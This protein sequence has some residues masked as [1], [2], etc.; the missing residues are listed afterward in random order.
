VQVF[1]R[2][3]TAIMVM[4]DNVGIWNLRAENLQRQYLG[5]ELYLRVVNPE[6]AATNNPY[7][8]T[9]VPD[10]VLYCGWLA[11]KQQNQ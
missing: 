11:Y 2:S 6:M 4:L 8:E 1:P 7:A 5:Q 9:P 3:W 10:N